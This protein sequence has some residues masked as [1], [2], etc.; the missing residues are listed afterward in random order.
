MSYPPAPWH[1][2][3]YALQSNHLIDVAKA[4]ELVPADLEIVSVL[5][6]KTLG[7]LYLSIYDAQSTLEYHELIVTPALVRY[8]G[9]IGS[10]ISHIYVDHRESLAG[11]RNIW[12][13]PKE[14]ADFTWND[15]QVQVAQGDRPLCQV[16]Y[17]QAGLPLSLWGKSKISGNVFAGLDENILA[18]PGDFEARLKWIS[19][20]LTIPAASPFAKLNLG[21][22]WFTLQFNELHLTANTPVVVG[23]WTT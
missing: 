20:H 10:W 13:L 12:G 22:P 21:H 17:S 3:G 4:K 19:C 14:M 8:Q 15:R 23:K 2:Y 5:P 6:G 9:Q 16:Q 7:G 18:F 1:L 11:G